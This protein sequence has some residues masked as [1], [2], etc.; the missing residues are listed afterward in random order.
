MLAAFRLMWRRRRWRHGRPLLRRTLLWLL[1]MVLLFA[2]S[3]A[4]FEGMAPQDSLWLAAVTLTTVGYGDV[5][6]QS[7]AGRIATALFL[8]LG[9]VFVVAKLASDWFDWRE[10][11]RERKR[12]GSWR[13]GMEG[14]VLVIGTPGGD[15]ER[16]FRGL[17]RQLAATPGYRDA[18]VLLLTRAFEANPAGLPDS[19]CQLGVV[20]VSGWPTDQDALT[21]AD[22]ATARAAIVLA[23]N[24]RE[25]VS[26]AVALDVIARLRAM[27]KGIPPVIV[28]ECVDDRNR[29]RML[30]AGAAAAA[31][32]L[33]TY[34][35]ML[36]R[37]LVAPGAEQLLEDL[38]SSE[39]NELHRVDL[40]ETWRGRWSALAG[41]V[42][43]RG[44]GTAVA[45]M[46]PNRAVVLNP[47]GPQEIEAIAIYVILDPG[48]AES[49]AGLPGILLP[50]RREA[51]A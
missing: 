5:V 46:A 19:L 32:P 31:R 35:E 23:E 16:F 6:P 48:Q 10:T 21:M 9:G 43:E 20:H 38:F 47:R 50:M 18:P 30:A 3:M 11:V 39:G 29:G 12:H 45:F 22:A 15:P 41:P 8:L 13:W 28:S 2:L 17:V 37:A 44:L 42:L 27:A 49:L 33:R 40:P 1:A 51:M 36:T 34:P 14:H 7:W 24:E 26:D 4:V 25:P